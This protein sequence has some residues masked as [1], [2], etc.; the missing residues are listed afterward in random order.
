MMSAVTAH[1]GTAGRQVPPL[2]PPQDAAR[3]FT[4]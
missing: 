4:R 3:G 2:L 1:P